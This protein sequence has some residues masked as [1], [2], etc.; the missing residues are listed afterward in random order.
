MFSATRP[1][2]CCVLILQRHLLRGG[3]GEPPRGNPHAQTLTAR[4]GIQPRGYTAPVGPSPE[5]FRTPTAP[6]ELVAPGKAARWHF[7][8]RGFLGDGTKA[9]TAGHTSRLTSGERQG[10]NHVP[11]LLELRLAR[12]NEHRADASGSDRAVPGEFGVGGQEDASGRQ[13]SAHEFRVVDAL[14]PGTHRAWRRTRM[15]APR[16]SSPHRL[17]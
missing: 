16:R 3:S 11:Q 13:G 14:D 9:A 8:S 6:E 2:V 5:H 1:T 4:E 17:P 15:P 10:P 7:G 12:G